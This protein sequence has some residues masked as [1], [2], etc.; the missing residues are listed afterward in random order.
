MRSP[1]VIIFIKEPDA[2]P[3]ID[4]RALIETFGLTARECQIVC[5]LA[6]GLGVTSIAASLKIRVGTVRQNLKSVFGKAG[7][8]NQAGLVA[9]VRNFGR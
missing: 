3:Q 2:P 8:H 4:E 9:L 5:L 7:V 1:R 6:G